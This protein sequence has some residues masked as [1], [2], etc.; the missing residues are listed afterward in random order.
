MPSPFLSKTWD[1][2]ARETQIKHM[3]AVVGLCACVCS[4]GRSRAEGKKRLRNSTLCVAYKDE[5][6]NLKEHSTRPERT[7]AHVF[8]IIRV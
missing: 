2:R 8:I 4:A 6:G 3:C 7:K 1:V 5:A